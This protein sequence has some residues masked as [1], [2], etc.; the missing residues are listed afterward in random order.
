MTRILVVHW[1]ESEARAKARTLH[2]LG[3]RAEILCGKEEGRMET[4]RESPP[5]LFLI[6]LE[7]LPSQGRE[8]AGYFR[9]LKSTRQVPIL[10]VD[11][12][13]DRVKRA[14]NLIPDA[15]FTKWQDLKDAIPKAIRK[16]P[17]KPV[18]PGTMAGLF[19]HAAAEEA[20]YSREFVCVAGERAGAFRAK[21]RAHA[22]RGGVR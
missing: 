17:A 1:N 20:G 16:R 19:R 7:R 12:D 15:E 9:R 13:S 22:Q 11:G 18:V 8:V 2:N 10:F 14:R 6:G 4:I 3:H 21:V 5:D